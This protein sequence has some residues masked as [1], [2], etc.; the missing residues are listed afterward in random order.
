MT[1]IDNLNVAV[2]CNILR[3]QILI[4]SMEWLPI[5][6]HASWMLKSSMIW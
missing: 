6:N 5:I 3:S 4:N 2:S 1:Q